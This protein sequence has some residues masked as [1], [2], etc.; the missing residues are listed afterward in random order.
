[1]LES[2]EQEKTYPVLTDV[3]NKKISHMP[4]YVWS[5]GEYVIQSLFVEHT[6]A[7]VST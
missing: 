4:R 5:I 7:I 6:C 1:M 2:A 3:S